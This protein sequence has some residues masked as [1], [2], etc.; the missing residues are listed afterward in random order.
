MALA[1][2]LQK[3]RGLVMT[4]QLRQALNFNRNAK[5]DTLIDDLA[6]NVPE[7]AEGETRSPKNRSWSAMA[8]HAGGG[9]RCLQRRYELG[10]IFRFANEHSSPAVG[11]DDETITGSALLKI[12]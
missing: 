4:P 2:L 12:D 9:D 7:C 8:I 11:A 1:R 10:V 5:T 3:Q 6:E